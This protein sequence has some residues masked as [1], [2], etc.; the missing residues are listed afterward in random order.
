MDAEVDPGK[1]VM[2]L[3]LQSASPEDIRR[4]AWATK[5]RLTEENWALWRSILLIDQIVANYASAVVDATWVWGWANEPQTSA[6]T[7]QGSK[8]T[9]DRGARVL[10]IA[11]DMVNQGAKIVTSKEIAKRLKVEGD[12]SSEKDLATGAGNIL[13]RAEGWRKV[14]PGEYAPVA[15]QT[16]IPAT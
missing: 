15:V 8:A 2:A 4:E 9:S 10:R 1:A 7:A 11:A 3:V 14:R 6:P 12:E 5:R 13:T 16:E